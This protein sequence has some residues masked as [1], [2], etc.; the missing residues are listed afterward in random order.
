MHNIGKHTAPTIVFLGTKDKLIPVK[1]A[2]AYRDKMKS[3][4]I[5]SELKLYEGEAH[6]FF[7]MGKGD[8]Y[9]KTLVQMD[10]F[11]T[12]VGFLKPDKK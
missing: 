12:D 7:N 8:S 9:P 11:L 2:E 4:G 6:G 10:Q 1:T 3:L 5:K